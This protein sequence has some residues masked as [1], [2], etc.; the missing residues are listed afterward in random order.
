MIH[1][2]IVLTMA[3]RGKGYNYLRFIDYETWAVRGQVS[4][5]KSLSEGVEARVEPS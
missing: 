1:W 4:Y 5:S 3:L 2:H